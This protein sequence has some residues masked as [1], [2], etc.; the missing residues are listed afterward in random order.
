MEAGPDP[1]QVGWGVAAAVIGLGAIG[2]VVRALFG[3]D[4]FFGGGA[5]AGADDAMRKFTDEIKNDLSGA[6][7]DL[8][9]MIASGQKDTRDILEKHS[10]AIGDLR[11]DVALAQNN[12]DHV[13]DRLDEH[14]RA[15]D[16]IESRRD[17]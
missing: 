11:R 17:K 13:K 3:R 12:H 7:L 16:R 14:Q 10:L 4:A 15:L 8:T 1:N 6:K 9:Q 2:A 5:Q